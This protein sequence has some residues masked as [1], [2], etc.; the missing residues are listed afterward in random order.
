MKYRDRT[1]FVTFPHS[2][3][4]S[5]GIEQDVRGVNVYRKFPE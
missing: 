3:T 4:Q 2:N 5:I 1:P